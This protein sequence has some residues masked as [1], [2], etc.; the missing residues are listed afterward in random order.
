M[1]RKN[2]YIIIICSIV[3]GI[4]LLK[5]YIVETDI[6]N[7]TKKTK[8]TIT[9]LMKLYQ[10][11]Y[12]LSYEYKVNGEKYSGQ[13][14]INPFKCEDGTE[15]CIGKEF[16]VYYSSKN[17]ENSRINLGKYEKFKTTIEFHNFE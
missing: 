11:R 5:H 8:G 13:T 1:K 14:G 17:P 2:F 9:K 10:A 6:K 16:D 4:F 12:S 3:I 15:N 7:N